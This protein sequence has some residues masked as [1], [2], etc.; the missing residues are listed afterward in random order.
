MKGKN[1]LHVLT[2]AIL[3]VYIV[4][5]AIGYNVNALAHSPYWRVL[6]MFFHGGF[7]HVAANALC[8]SAIARSDFKVP[9]NFVVMALVAAVC[10]PMS[11]DAVTLGSSGVC[12]ALLGA[13]SWQSNDIRK[14][15]SMITLFIAIGFLPWVHVN[16]MLHAFCYVEGVMYG[17]LCKD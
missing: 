8:F 4:V 11:D 2:V 17:W 9:S 1:L 13:M 14:Y 16:C 5:T 10:A 3:A 12:Y 6:Y 15:H 7:L